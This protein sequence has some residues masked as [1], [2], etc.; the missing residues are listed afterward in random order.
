METVFLYLRYDSFTLV[1]PFT[2]LRMVYFRF[3]LRLEN[4]GNFLAGVTGHPV[5]FRSL[6]WKN[7][8]VLPHWDPRFSPHAVEILYKIISLSVISFATGHRD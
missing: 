1:L 7:L 8:F 2:N 6:N 5:A 3:L 4:N